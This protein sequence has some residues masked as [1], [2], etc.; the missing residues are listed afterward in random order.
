ME[1]NAL[2]TTAK[3][4]IDVVKAERPDAVKGE[5]SSLCLIATDDEQLFTGITGVKINN[6]TVS[7]V[8]SEYNAIMSMLVE[9]RINAKQMITVAFDG[10][11]TIKKPCSDCI[12]LLYRINKANND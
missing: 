10:K 6:T 2:Y 12:K 1:I 9:N 4:M 7:T 11:Y 8:C 3:A 5:D